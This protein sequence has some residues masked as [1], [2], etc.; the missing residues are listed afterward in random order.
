MLNILRRIFETESARIVRESKEFMDNRDQLTYGFKP[1]EQRVW[2]EA[3][4]VYPS[5]IVR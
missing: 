3:I 5:D 4:V 2:R 1:G